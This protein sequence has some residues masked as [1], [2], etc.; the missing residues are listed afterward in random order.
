MDTRNAL[1]RMASAISTAS[2]VESVSE[3]VLLASERFAVSVR[4]LTNEQI[5]EYMNEKASGGQI[6]LFAESKCSYAD[7]AE[8]EISKRF[9]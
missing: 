4:E 5:C 6:S 8:E 9:K 1:L 2:G 3:I 7:V